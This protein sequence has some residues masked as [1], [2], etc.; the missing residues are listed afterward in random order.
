MTNPCLH[1][2]IKIAAHEGRVTVVFDGKVIADSIRALDLDEPGYPMR[3]YIPRE[4]VSADVL[5]DSAHHSYCPYKG[6]ASYHSLLTDNEKAENAVWYY[7]DPCPLVE[8]IRDHLAFW[9]N[10]IR[11]EPA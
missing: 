3:I 1:R 10:Q 4:D 8:P 11:Y 6:D 5:T 7:A 2:D 9:G